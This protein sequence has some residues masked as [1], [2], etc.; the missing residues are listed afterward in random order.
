M[1]VDGY[2]IVGKYGSELV[3]YPE[4][5]TSRVQA[6]HSMEEAENWFTSNIGNGFNL[7]VKLAEKA[8]LEA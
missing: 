6:F 3:E 7:M 8:I 2:I 5:F 4:I 1:L